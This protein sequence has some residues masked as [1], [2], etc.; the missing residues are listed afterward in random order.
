MAAGGVGVLRVA[1]LLGESQ[2]LARAPLGGRRCRPARRSWSARWHC[3][4][5]R[6]R[7]GARPPP[8]R[9]PPP[10]GPGPPRP[11]RRWRGGRCRGPGRLTA[12]S[13]DARRG[14]SEH[15]RPADLHGRPASPASR[16]SSERRGGQAGR[17][18]RGRSP[19]PPQRAAPRPRR[20]RAAASSG[21]PRLMPIQAPG[22]AQARVAVHAARPAAARASA[23]WC[24]SSRCAHSLRPVLGDQVGGPVRGRRRRRDGGS[25]RR[26]RP[27]SRCQ[28][29]ARRCSSGDLARA[30]SGPA[31]GAA[32]R[33]RGG[34]SGTTRG[35]CPGA[36]GRGSSARARPASRA[37]SAV[38]ATASHSGPRQ[39]PEDR[40]AQQEP[41]RAPGAGP[42]APPRRGSP[43]PAGRR[44]RRRR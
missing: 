15:G 7:P 2:R 37:A 6:R 17:E 40:G 24:R 28:P 26:W 8:G 32:A 11:A 36:P 31:R 23:R 10:P 29:A 20:A 33:R 25:P 35:G 16:R 19:R 4:H 13:H 1:L 3:G 27:S 43:P 41:P 44:R 18:R 21:R 5:Q 42:R 34:G 30:R 39:P 14:G 12:R 38:P 22:Q 9:R